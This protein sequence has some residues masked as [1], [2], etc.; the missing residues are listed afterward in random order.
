V[1]W[2]GS[3]AVHVFAVD[4]LERALALRDALPYHVAHKKVPHLDA[5]GQL[6]EPSEPNALKFERFIFDLLPHAKNAIVVEYPEDEV[7]APLKNAPGADRDT[8]EYV[9]RLMCDQH[10]GWLREASVEVADEVDV[11][12]S[13]L[14]ALDAASVRNRTDLPA[15]ID[16]PTYL[17]DEA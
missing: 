14:W 8:P 17:R 3:I 13:P 7:F 2:A 4:F 12:I 10:R 11:E 9:R 6:V 5:T 1:F 16:K 15:S